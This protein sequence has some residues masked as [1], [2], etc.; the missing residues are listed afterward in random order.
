MN[1]ITVKAPAISCGHCV[2][3]IQSEV[4]ELTGVQSVVAA[5][6]TKLVTIAY[7]DPATKEQIEALMAE[8][9]YPV[10]K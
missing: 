8:I 2:K 4:G 7:D 3:T 9:G 10:E 6:D 1:T 5:Q